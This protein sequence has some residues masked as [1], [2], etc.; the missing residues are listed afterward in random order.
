MDYY[1]K[2]FVTRYIGYSP[3]PNSWFIGYYHFEPPSSQGSNNKGSN[4]KGSNR[5][6]SKSTYAVFSS[7]VV[8][9]IVS[10]KKYI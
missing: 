2:P 4:N 1:N 3:R 9:G 10:V 7:E 8:D 6:N 5:R